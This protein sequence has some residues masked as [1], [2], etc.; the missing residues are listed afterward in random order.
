[1]SN[2]E[3]R[4][5]VKFEADAKGVEA[6]T[7]RISKAA[8]KLSK[9]QKQTFS[10]SLKTQK[11]ADKVAGPRAQRQTTAELKKQ[12]TEI[13][14][15][16]RLL[17]TLE[18]GWRRVGAAAKSAFKA[19]EGSGMDATRAR[20]SARRQTG[21]SGGVR[22]G[23]GPN[24]NFSRYGIG[25]GLAS[26][27]RAGIGLAGGGLAALATMPFA[28]VSADYQAYHTYMRSMAGL[29]GLNKGARFGTGITVGGVDS[30]ARGALGQL[31]YSPEET[32]AGYRQ[33]GRATGS[34]NDTQLGMT[35]ARVLGM[36]PTEIA[37]IFG[38]LRRGGGTFGEKGT[39][40]FQRI[41]Q[42]AVKGGVDASTLPE[43][44]EGL[45]SLTASASGRAGGNVSA[46]PY[47]QLLSLF[48]KSGA[49]GLKGARGA[50][51][52]SALEEGFKS[53]GGGDEGL[54]AI[55]GSLGFGRAGGNTSYYSAKKM[56]QQGFQGGSGQLRNLFDYV[57]RI[58]GGGEEAN[59]YMEGLMGGRL[60]LDQIEKVRGAMAQGTPSTQLDAML[61][62][63]TESELDVLQSIDENLAEFL[64]AAARTTGIQF[65]SIDRGREY[66]PTVESLQD[67]MNTFIHD[68]MPLV[69]TTMDR[70]A[71]AL[72]FLLPGFEGLVQTINKA[73]GVDAEGE[74]FTDPGFINT[75]GIERVQS[76]AGAL[77]LA[78]AAADEGDTTDEEL[79]AVMSSAMNHRQAMHDLYANPDFLTSVGEMFG[80]I[81]GA[82]PTDAANAQ[83]RD[84]L[85]VAAR[86][87]DQLA[88]RMGRGAEVDP[89]NIRTAEDFTA[90]LTALGIAIPAGSRARVD[91]SGGAP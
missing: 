22:A 57:D 56:M 6:E 85:R 11:D 58:T 54:A 81:S 1:M 47:A 64:H 68:M 33:F 37:G 21:F 14:T 75:Q 91:T 66:A 45:K 25:H 88:E 17:Q 82:S 51:V 23:L 86:A 65:Q 26:G 12:N 27:F 16:A 36:D 63:M 78:R 43:Y 19:T 53:P 8:N 18:A 34:S 71:D 77:S 79:R 38:E 9:D 74:H 41:L 24:P 84:D 31:G 87:L 46:L 89:A 67:M 3:H 4:V 69:K 61:K 13:R 70:V 28:A 59:L 40:D 39:K 50:S 73:M 32:V 15:S 10:Q 20:R 83:M 30:A 48:E 29:S 76:A 60:S 52:L 44:L 62:D 35:A 5:L 72:E 42:A 80:S 90:A 55:M 49:S 2:T 7:R